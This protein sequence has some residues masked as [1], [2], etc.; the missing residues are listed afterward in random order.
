M[1]LIF[2]LGNPEPQYSW[3][4]HNVG[5]EFVNYLSAVS[6]LD[7][8]VLE[9]N[10]WDHNKKTNSY[11]MKLD[12][13]LL[14]KPDCYMNTVGEVIQKVVS[15]YKTPMDHVLIVYDELDFKVGEYKLGFSKG[16][17]IHNGIK[18]ITGITGEN[19]FWNLRI[20][21]REP[22]IGVSVQ[23]SGKDPSQYVLQRFPISHKKK[24]L[25]TYKEIVKTELNG[26][27]SKKM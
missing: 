3:T 19:N 8:P 11:E 5:K 27:L 14:I 21:V 12:D 6:R 22:N 2:G 7:E 24:I 16:S 15:Y 18:S 1:K 20:G 26:W 9:G 17:R 23:K 13:Y 25:E 4:R 10:F